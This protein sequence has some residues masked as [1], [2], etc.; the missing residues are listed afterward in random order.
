[1]LRKSEAYCLLNPVHILLWLEV[2]FLCSDMRKLE[3]HGGF[4]APKQSTE[5]HR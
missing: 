4:A 3:E 2:N 1:M 5:Y